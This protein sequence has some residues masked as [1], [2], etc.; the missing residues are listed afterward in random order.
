M[1]KKILD[2]NIVFFKTAGHMFVYY[3]LTFTGSAL[4]SRLGVSWKHYKDKTE[5]NNLINYIK[6]IIEKDIPEKDNDIIQAIVNLEDCY[7]DLL[8]IKK[9]EK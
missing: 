5:V 1:K 4:Y 8:D 7:Y 2:K 9:E 6:E 3:L